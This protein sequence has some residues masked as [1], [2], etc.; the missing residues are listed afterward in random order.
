MLPSEKIVARIDFVFIFI[1]LNTPPGL[2]GTSLNLL[3][4][5]PGDW[6]AAGNAACMV[7][8][9]YEHRY[10]EMSTGISEI[11]EISVCTVSPEIGALRDAAPVTRPRGGGNLG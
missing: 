11:P 4:G 3:F 6:H 1:A 2:I 10:W 7:H 5:L 9:Y 8:H